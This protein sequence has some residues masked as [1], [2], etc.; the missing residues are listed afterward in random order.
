MTSYHRPDL[1]PTPQAITD[2]RLQG[3]RQGCAISEDARTDLRAQN[4]Q[5]VEERTA[6]AREALLW[7]ARWNAGEQ[8]RDALRAQV[9]RLR[10]ALLEYGQHSLLCERR[11]ASGEAC[12][13]GLAAAMGGK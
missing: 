8:E 6:A 9:E 4:A 3:Y 13:C 2:A 5:L 10:A 1:E 11:Q 12:V 7:R